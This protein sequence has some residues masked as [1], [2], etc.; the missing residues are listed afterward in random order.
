MD[1]AYED[2]TCDQPFVIWGLRGMGKTALLNYLVERAADQD[3]MVISVEAASDES[4]AKRISQAIAQELRRYERSG[5]PLTAAFK[6]ARSV[7]KS[8]QLKFDP[9]GATSFGFNVDPA[10]GYADSGDSAMDLQDIMHAL[11]DA[12]REQGSAVLITIDELQ[13]ASK[14]DLSALNRAL[15]GIGQEIDPVPL[16]FVGAGLPDLPAVLADATSY[17]ERMYRFFS[18]GSLSEDESLEALRVPAMNKQVFWE[19]KA[20]RRAVEFS[21]GYPY[22]IQQSGRCAWDARTVRDVI[23]AEDCK[24]G[25]AIAQNEIDQGLYRSRWDRA[26]DAER[27]FLKA[28][29]S[30]GAE[31]PI[32]EIAQHLGKR[33]LKELSVVRQALIKKG[34]IYSPERGKVAFALPGFDGYIRRI[35]AV[36][37]G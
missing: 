25:L 12:A 36:S 3:W 6:F 16:V 7:L 23:T 19:E 9:T 32:S 21:Q 8:F 14:A 33:D 15:H 30:I 22:F 29:A 27:D 18:I 10:Q 24:E 34:Q 13:E 11:G 1:R 37:P 5:K 17:A 4:L 35:T 26:T 20:L 2:E 28:M 31:A